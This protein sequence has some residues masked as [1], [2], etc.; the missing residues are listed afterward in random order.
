[1]YLLQE[2]IAEEVQGQKSETLEGHNNSN[3]R[4]TAR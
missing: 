4:V 3:G 1:M 2:E